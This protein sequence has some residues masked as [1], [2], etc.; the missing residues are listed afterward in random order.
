VNLFFSARQSF[1]LIELLVVMAIIATLTSL[2]L[3]SLKYARDQAK[4]AKCQSNLH[5]IGL[6][7]HMYAND[8]EDYLPYART[9][10]WEDP[11][12]PPGGAEPSYCQDLLRTYLSGPEVG[13]GTNSPVFTCPSV[14][15]AWV[16]N[17]T[18]R[19]DYRYNYWFCNAWNLNQAGRKIGRLAKPS[20]AILLYDMAWDDWPFSDLPHEGVNAVYADGRVG[21]IKGADFISLCDEQTGPIMSDGF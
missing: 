11:P 7:F 14:K 18:P 3:P 16:L 17:T 5:Q 21:Y 8:R 4:R 15:V 12:N 13:M 10:D 9:F 6:A 1:T 20:A 2:L 19:N